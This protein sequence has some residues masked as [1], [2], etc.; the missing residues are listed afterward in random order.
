VA[1]PTTSEPVSAETAADPDAL[2]DV[3]TG[4]QLAPA[5]ELLQTKP[6]HRDVRAEFAM[7]ASTTAGG[8]SLHGGSKGKASQNRRAAS[9]VSVGLQF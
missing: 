5:S 3:V 9:S 4:A 7:E 2:L 6:Q 8:S 1:T